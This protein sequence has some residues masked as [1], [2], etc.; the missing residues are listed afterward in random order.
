VF[1][2]ERRSKPNPNPGTGPKKLQPTF[3]SSARDYTELCNPG[4]L[5]P[6]PLADVFASHFQVS[7]N[8]KTPFLSIQLIHFFSIPALVLWVLHLDAIVSP[9]D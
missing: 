4:R 8:F 3:S 1:R 7:S 5:Q 6:K 9:P 2:A